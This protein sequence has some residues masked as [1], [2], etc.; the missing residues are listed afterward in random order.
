[1]K[2]NSKIEKFIKELNKVLIKYPIDCTIIHCLSLNRANESFIDLVK[3]NKTDLRLKHAWPKFLNKE[4]DDKTKILLTE[5]NIKESEIQRLRK[6]I[7]KLER[8]HIHL[9]NNFQTH[10]CTYVKGSQI[11]FT[12]QNI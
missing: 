5:A 9:F 3:I 11:V 10:Y 12:T 4:Q 6:D 1:M 8:R 7:H 2:K